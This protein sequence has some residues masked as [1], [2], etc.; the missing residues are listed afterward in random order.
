VAD[1]RQYQVY[2]HRCPFREVAQHH[3]D[4]VCS[5]HLG[6]MQGALDQ[7][8][9]LITATGWSRSPSPTCASPI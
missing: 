1:G 2:L 3:Q 4:M 5:L 8:R 6:L 9:A 7:M